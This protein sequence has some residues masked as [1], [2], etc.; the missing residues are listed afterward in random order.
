MKAPLKICILLLVVCF[1]SISAAVAEERPVFLLTI[2]D[3]KFEPAT[4]ELPAGVKVELHVKN[5]DATPE[6][7]ESVELNREKVISAGQEGR[8]Y[9]GP[10]QPGTYNFFGD[11][12]PATA[13]GKF[14][15]K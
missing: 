12:N 3:H 14:I 13:R 4:L 8:I 5:A 1:A 15:V 6:E 10:L 2:K 7:F 11:F 9:I